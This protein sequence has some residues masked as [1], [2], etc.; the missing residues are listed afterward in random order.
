MLKQL[1]KDGVITKEDYWVYL[2]HTEET[3]QKLLKYQKEELFKAT[4]KDINS[5]AEWNFLEGSRNNIK[6]IEF[7]IAFIEN[8]LEELK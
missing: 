2:V 5:I 8:K 7:T 4:P 3:A 1:L 6:K